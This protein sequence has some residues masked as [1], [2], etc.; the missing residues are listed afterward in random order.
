MAASGLLGWKD[1]PLLISKCRK[2]PCCNLI[3]IINGK[4]LMIF[5]RR[6]LYGPASF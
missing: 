1:T 5:A 2:T 4:S 3:G 6:L